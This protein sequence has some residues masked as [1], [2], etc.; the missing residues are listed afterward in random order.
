[1]IT[2][3]KLC[4]HIELNMPNISCSAANN[5]KLNTISNDNI[6]N[7]DILTFENMFNF[8]QEIKAMYQE[9][10]IS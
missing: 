1:M 9:V 5:I 10:I 2:T 8:V 7:S 4:F 6:N 3:Q